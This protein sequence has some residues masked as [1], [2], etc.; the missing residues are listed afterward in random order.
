MLVAFASTA[1]FPA[2]AAVAPLSPAELKKQASHVVT[3]SVVEVTSK[4]RKSQVERAIGIHRD[5]I[6][7]IRIKVEKVSKGDGVK[8][9]SEI[10]IVAWQP[11]TRIPPLPGHQGHG[12]IPQK[13]D[14]ATFYL[15]AK[16][17]KQF[18]PLLPNGIELIKLKP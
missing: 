12:S 16:G 7:T 17:E 4:T 18:E 5:L 1:I 2:L 8:V 6:H 10:E 9:G 3:G 15:R 13:G 14:K 11:S